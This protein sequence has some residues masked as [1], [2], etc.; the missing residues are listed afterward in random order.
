[1][2]M[3][4]WQVGACCIL[5]LAWAGPVRAGSKVY[6]PTVNKGEIEIENRG[7]VTDDKDPS[8]SGDLSMKTGVGYGVTDWWFAEAYAITSRTPGG[9]HFGLDGVEFESLFQLTPTGKYWADFGALA[10]YTIA[11]KN[12]GHDE[13]ELTAIVEKEI[14][15]TIHTANLTFVKELGSRA[16]DVE[17]EYAWAS[18][19]RLSPFFQPG[20]EA[21]GKAGELKD[22]A[23][24]DEQEH[25][26]GP[27]LTGRIPISFGPGKLYYEAA[28]LFGLTKASPDGAFRWLLEYELRF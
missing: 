3:P 17:L 22:L 26:I 19:W 25:Q 21:F 12:G 27:A 15:R 4:V 16:E 9:D 11:T 6:S 8:K 20:F 13:L 28:Y 24:I 1:M 14:G 23:P 2:K 7:I 5:A 10:E 18:R